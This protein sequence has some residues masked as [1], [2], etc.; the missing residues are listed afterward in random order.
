MITFPNLVP[1]ENPKRGCLEGIIFIV[2]LL[3][4]LVIVFVL[5]T[6]FVN[7]DPFKDAT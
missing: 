6:V 3:V 5:F 1:D 7:D 4:I 2:M